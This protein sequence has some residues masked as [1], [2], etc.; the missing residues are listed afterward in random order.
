MTI[1]LR[2]CEEFPDRPF[3]SHPEAFDWKEVTGKEFAQ[4]IR[5]V[6]KGIVAN[7]I[8]QNDRVALMAESSFE[9]TVMDFA[10]WAAGAASVPIYPSSSAS[11]VQWIVEDSGAKLAIADEGANQSL[12]TNLVVGEN[13]HAPLYDSPTQLQ[14][15]LSFSKGAIETLIDDGKD[16]DDAI[17][18]ERI[19]AI[20]HDDLASLVYTSGTTGKPKGC[21]LTH[22]VWAHQAMALL[23]NPIGSIANTHPG[24]RY[25][26]V[27]PLAHVLARSV[28]LAW[29]L[30]A[31]HQAHWSNTS[32]IPLAFQRFQPQ[33]ILGVPRIFEKVRDGAYNKAADG[34][35]F[36]ARVF[37]EAEKTAIEYSKAL[38]TDKGPG[39]VLKARRALFDKLVYSKLRE[40]MGN[41]AE[42]AIS[43]GSAISTN[44]LHF[45]RGLGLPIYE[46][47]GLTETAAAAAVNCPGHTKI[48]TVGRPNNGYSV[49]IA[50][51]GEIC[52]KGDGVFLGYWNNPEATAEAIKDGWF[53]TGD[54]GTVDEEGYV[55]ITGRKK[56]LIVTAGGKNISPGPMED[57]LRSHPLISQAIII[58]DDKK[59]VTVLITLDEDELRRWKKTNNIPE[60]MA[61]SELIKKSAD[62]RTEIQFAV[63]EAN[64]TVSNAEQIKKFRV[65]PRDLS[66]EEGEITP[67]LKV[68]R[69]VV[70]EHFSKQIDR[71]YR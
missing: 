10:I 6:A 43:G 20:K 9:W 62:L 47:Y 53:H 63:N 25:M 35:S 12:F 50:D 11:Q 68:K 31:G 16:V 61:V 29:A 48:G 19:K 46:G 26:T 54:L 60:D 18:D 36:S 15:V 24:A 44:L 38:D 34:S 66:E 41:H 13:G 3:L 30:G 42:F 21:I 8:E 27:L 14:R 59:Y 5:D 28:E 69:N 56:D 22:L 64:Q 65:L 23:T 67:T 40:A 32:T 17:I 39:V 37:L 7:G 70:Q 4:L 51:D 33:M 58:G 1:T 52:F 45:F 49:K 55:T 71:L 2:K 57:I